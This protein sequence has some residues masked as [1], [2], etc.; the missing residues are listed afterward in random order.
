MADL[1]GFK[2]DRQGT[3]IEKDPYS[4]LDYTLA[5]ADWMPSSTVI[6]SITVTA[7]AIT[8]DTAALVIDSSTNTTTNVTATISGGTVGNIYNVEYRIVTDTSLRDSRNFRIKV[9][10]REL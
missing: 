4:V 8:G 2:Q 5:W 1:T 3:Y 6:S 9:V 10:E 7:Q